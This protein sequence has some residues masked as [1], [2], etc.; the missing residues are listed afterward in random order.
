MVE[1]GTS[2]APFR[3]SAIAVGAALAAEAEGAH[4]IWYADG[5]AVDVA[6]E[7]WRAQAGALSAIAPD[8]TDLADPIVTAAAALLVARR[9]RVG[10]LGWNPGPDSTRAARTVAT[11]AD[12][13]PGRAVVSCGGTSEEVVGLAGAIRPD[14]DLELA[15]Y[16][17]APETAARLG[18]GWIGI[19]QSP[20][21]VAKLASDAGVTGTLGVH[22]P[23]LIHADA[24]VAQAALD[25]PLLRAMGIE[26]LTDAVVV[27]THAA[28]DT[29]IDR[30]VHAGVTRIILEN[31]L[32]FGAPQELEASRVALR[33]SMRS[34][35]LRHRAAP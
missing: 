17:G 25:A 14:L 26:A 24:A 1:I 18:W 10:V 8:P 13:A 33:A 2:G 29:A 19:A 35:R 7:Q 11:L 16:G 21:A 12:L 30:Y 6:P 31:L 34:A 15:V 9:L 23:V 4:A 32:P 20:I 27:G 3:S 28:L 5:L 22:L